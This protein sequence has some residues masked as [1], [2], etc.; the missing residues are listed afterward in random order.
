MLFDVFAD[1]EEFDVTTQELG[2]LSWDTCER[3]STVAT[4]TEELDMPEFA[5]VS[6]ISKNIYMSVIIANF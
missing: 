5:T 6:L 3:L 4:V 1:D 2:L